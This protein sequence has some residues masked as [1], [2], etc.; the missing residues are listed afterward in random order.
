MLHFVDL[1]LKSIS[2]HSEAF[3]EK[4]ILG[5]KYFASQK[6]QNTCKIAKIGAKWLSISWRQ[7][8]LPKCPNNGL[9]SRPY[10]VFF[11]TLARG[12]G[13]DGMQQM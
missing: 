5:E 6:N 4:T 2:R 7:N 12:G 8:I 3:W 13:P 10:I 1:C 9:V 11:V